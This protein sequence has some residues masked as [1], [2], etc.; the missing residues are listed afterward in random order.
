MSMNSH[1]IITSSRE[2]TLFLS[3]MFAPFNELMIA[4]LTDKTVQLYNYQT[5]KLRSTL[6]GHD[7]RVNVVSFSSEKEKVISGSADR[8]IKIWDVNK[9]SSL[10][11][12][13]CGSIVRSIDYFQS[14]P[15]FVTGHND[16]SLRIYSVRDNANIKPIINIKGVFDGG[17]TSVRLSNCHNYV[18]ASST[19]GFAVKSIDLR[20]GELFKSYENQSYFNNHEFNKC[21]FGPDDK[22]VIAGSSDNSILI[23][24]FLTG[25][26]KAILK[27]PQHQGVIVVVDFHNITG[28]LFSGDS[29]GN[30]VVWK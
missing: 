28:N 4:G 16:G 19:D 9:G 18:L 15:H 21:C 5:C 14:E 10:K 29:R 2:D 7:D 13:P 11:S 6:Q 30:L 20:K 12:I 24:E 3:T 1:G 22:Y 25:K 27:S 26:K 8:S 23:W 17:I